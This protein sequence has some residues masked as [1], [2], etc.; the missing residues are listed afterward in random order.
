[1]KTTNSWEGS[2]NRLS[3]TWTETVGNLADSDAIVAAI[4]SLNGL[5]SAVNS[6]TAGL[7]LLGTTA[8]SGAGIG[9]AAFVKNFA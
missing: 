3:N 8:L 9:I 5:L 6:L 2:L 7:G 1:E 4:N